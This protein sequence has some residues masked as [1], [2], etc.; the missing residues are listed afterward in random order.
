[1]FIHKIDENLSLKL[2][3]L[4][5]AEEFFALTDSSRDYLREWLPWLDG[6]KSPED[7]KE[8]IQYSLKNY[9]QQKSLTALI[10]FKGE[11]AGTAGFNQID[12][13]NGIAYIG[14]WLGQGFQGLGIMT[15]VVESLIDHA[16]SELEMNKVEI[17]AAVEN[18]KS[19]GIPERLGFVKE[20]RIRCAEKLYGKYVDHEVYGLLLEEW[21]KKQN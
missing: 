4:K 13:S 11:I 20:G 19:R 1:M 2:P 18:R 12:R 10:L 15:R 5:D 6:T 8:F 16:F 21:K 14:Y 17:R 3:E 7:T 9:A